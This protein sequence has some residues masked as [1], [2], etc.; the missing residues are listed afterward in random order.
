MNK[1]PP[2]PPLPLTTLPWECQVLFFLPPF[3]EV[4]GYDECSL[5][6]ELYF[7]VPPPSPPSPPPSVP[8]LGLFSLPL[9]MSVAW[10]VRV[11]QVEEG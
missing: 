4:L 5:P 11:C 10:E 9:V 7:L 1:C 8:C 6:V 3:S 2:H